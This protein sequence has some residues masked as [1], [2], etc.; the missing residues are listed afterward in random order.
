[1]Y[2]HSFHRNKKTNG[3][4]IDLVSGQDGSPQKA[5]QN[6]TSSA[7][8]TWVFRP[9]RGSRRLRFL[10][11]LP[12]TRVRSRSTPLAVRPPGCPVLV[13]VFPGDLGRWKSHAFGRNCTPV[14]SIQNSVSWK[15]SKDREM[16]ETNFRNSG[17][18]FFL[19]WRCPVPY[20]RTT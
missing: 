12:E 11:P 9:P 4:G 18:L 1:M 2:S 17:H 19:T 6:G 8:T 5:Q 13:Q 7:V 16:L 10:T 20:R 15:Y 14:W 3:F